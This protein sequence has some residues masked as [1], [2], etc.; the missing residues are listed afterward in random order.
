MTTAASSDVFIPAGSYCYQ[1]LEV[2]ERPGQFPLLRTRPCG[3]FEKVGET[4]RCNLLAVQDDLLLDDSC[5]ICGL[6][7]CVEN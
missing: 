4:N 3:H 6:N 5:K 7:E 2:V 1:L